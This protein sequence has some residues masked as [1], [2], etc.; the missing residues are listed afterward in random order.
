M[1]RSLE[2]SSQSM[3]IK[4]LTIILSKC[5]ISPAESSEKEC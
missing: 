2:N 1:Q 5:V 3:V 4:I